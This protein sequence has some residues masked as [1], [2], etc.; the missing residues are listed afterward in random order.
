MARAY[1]NFGVPFE[2]RVQ[3]TEAIRTGNFVFVSGMSAL[4][5]EGRVIGP[6]DPEVQ[7]RATFEAIR[8]ALG[9][10]GA[11]MKDVVME[12]EFVTDMALY[13]PIARIRQEYF[14]S[15]YPTATLVVVKALWKPGLVFEA[16]AIAVVGD[17]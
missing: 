10:A 4:D 5:D 1:F 7:G 16:N 15:N 12:T 17:P 11:T 9:L 6:G 13:K 14:P 8:R 2:R 3:F